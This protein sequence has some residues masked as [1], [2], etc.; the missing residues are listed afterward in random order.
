MLENA[1]GPIYLYL[2]K[3]HINWLD[4]AIHTINW[5]SGKNYVLIEFIVIVN[6]IIL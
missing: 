5:N 3:L 2:G 4:L 6:Y 1:N